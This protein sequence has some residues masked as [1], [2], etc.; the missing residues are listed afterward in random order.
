MYYSAAELSM[1]QHSCSAASPTSS[2]GVK[3][4]FIKDHRH[5]SRQWQSSSIKKLR[6]R[7]WRGGRFG[8]KS[9]TEDESPLQICWCS[10]PIPSTSLIRNAIR[11]DFSGWLLITDS[12]LIRNTNKCHSHTVMRLSPRA[13][14]HI[15]LHACTCTNKSSLKESCPQ[16]IAVTI[17]QLMWLICRRQFPSCLGEG[18]QTRI[19]QSRGT[20]SEQTLRAANARNKCQHFPRTSRW[21][22]F[23]QHTAAWWK[24]NSWGRTRWEGLPR[25]K[26][27]TPDAALEPFN[28]IRPVKC[29][30]ACGWWNIKRRVTAA[31]THLSVPADGLTDAEAHTCIQASWVIA[32]AWVLEGRH[33]GRTGLSGSIK[34]PSHGSPHCLGGLAV[35]C[36]SVRT[37]TD[38]L[39]PRWRWDEW[40]CAAGA[41]ATHGVP[42]TVLF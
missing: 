24:S 39:S 22:C 14:Q 17:I 42:V 3:T 40:M 18:L 29:A 13:P 5:E 15:S 6:W 28:Q 12:K 4:N 19:E 41:V 2:P 32:V 9:I 33:F 8:W 37:G 27:E 31:R 16:S 36:V 35:V 26:W 7:A 1:E 25:S 11:E 10:S 30:G 21:F 20:S 23:C 38:M 34:W